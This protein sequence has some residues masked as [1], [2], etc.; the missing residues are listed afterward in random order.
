MHF[1]CWNDE[2]NSR[3]IR[4][5]FRLIWHAALWTI[6]RERNARIFKNQFKCVDELVD[7]VKALSWCWALNRLC[8]ASCLYYEW[9]WNPRDAQE[10]LMGVSWLGV[11]RQQ[12]GCFLGAFFCCFC[13]C[14]Q[15]LFSLLS[16][17]S[18]RWFSRC[19]FAFVTCI[20][21][22]WLWLLQVQLLLFFPCLCRL[23]FGVFAPLYFLSLPLSHV[24]WC[25]GS[26]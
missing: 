18:S 2:V 4:K 3:Q 26:L 9:C 7:E 1:A 20:L 6:W 17:F 14:E 21:V 12:L 16:T 25:I 15:L 24:F 5:A 8:I 10:A 23:H 22:Y 11:F 13:W 19:V